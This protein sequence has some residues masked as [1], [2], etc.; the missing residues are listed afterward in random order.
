[1]KKLD[2]FIAQYGLTQGAKN[3]II[4]HTAMYAVA[5]ALRSAKPKAA[6]IA[7]MDVDLLT[8]EVMDACMKKVQEVYEAQG[9]NDKAAKGPRM[10]EIL[11]RDL[12]QR[13]TE[14]LRAKR[15]APAK[16]PAPAR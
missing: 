8:D 10:G 9:G 12:E 15:V 14:P 5:R 4:F 13:L 1:M 7:G 2:D 6:G 3:N 16:R 11:K